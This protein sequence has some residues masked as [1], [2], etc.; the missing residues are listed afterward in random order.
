[1]AQE[2][3]HGHITTLQFAKN[4]R[5]SGRPVPR[6]G[7]FGFVSG[8]G[9][10]Q[11]VV[12][13]TKRFAEIELGF[14]EIDM[15]LPVRDQRVEQVFR[16]IIPDL[17]AMLAR[18]DVKG[19]GPVLGGE[20]GF[21]GF[22]VVLPD[23]QRV[24]FLQVGMASRCWSRCEIPMKVMIGAK[25]LRIQRKPSDF[26]GI[27]VKLRAALTQQ[28]IQLRHRAAMRGAGAYFVRISFPARVIRRM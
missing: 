21:E 2:R 27:G 10:K 17:I 22:L 20:I 16:D 5:L 15:A 6:H 13:L 12:F 7:L 26:I 24:E 28:P 23:P 19:A 11:A 4:A 9:L 1:M 8:L 25:S 18:L 3:I 14:Q